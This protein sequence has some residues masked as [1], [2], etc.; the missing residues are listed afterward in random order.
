[1]PDGGFGVE[2]G[3]VGAAGSAYSKEGDEL[4]SAGSK[5]E[6][7]VGM[8]KVGKAW[9]DI[10]GPYTEAISKFRDTVI[11]YG[12]VVTELGGQLSTAAKSYEKGE[13]ASQDSFTRKG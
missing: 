3:K 8:G 10:A 4:V 2:P 13:E 5:I 11:S 9:G 1:M 12:E 6:T 7:D